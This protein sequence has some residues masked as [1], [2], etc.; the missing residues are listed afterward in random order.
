MANGCLSPYG[1]ILITPVASHIHMKF[2]VIILTTYL[3]YQYGVQGITLLN[4]ALLRLAI[5]T[6]LRQKSEHNPT[7]K[8][9]GILFNLIFLSIYS[10]DRI[11]NFVVARIS[12]S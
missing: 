2:D 9:K 11:L 4:S 6:V 12:S 7:F 3:P 5:N 8:P 1:P 10:D